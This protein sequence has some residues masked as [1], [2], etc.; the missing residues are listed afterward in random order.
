VRPRRPDRR[1][2]GAV[3]VGDDHHVGVG[4]GA[5]ERVGEGGSARVAVWL[6]D[7]HN[8]PPVARA[9]GR[10]R[11]TH[12]ARQ[13]G[14]VVDEG[15]AVALA[16]ELEAPGHPG[17]AGEGGGGGLERCADLEGGDGGDGRVAGVV[18]PRHR[19]RQPAEP[20]A[21]PTRSKATA[22]RPSST[23]SIT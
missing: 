11:G 15:D 12:L 14:V 19:H 7:G 9:R 4:E 20:A 23:S 1:L 18:E 17:E 3:D 6:E 8:P 2:A 22:L 21:R 16:P 5:G 10:Q 13:V